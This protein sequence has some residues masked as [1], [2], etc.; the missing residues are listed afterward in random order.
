MKSTDKNLQNNTITGQHQQLTTG[1]ISQSQQAH[2][3]DSVVAVVPNDDTESE[4]VTGAVESTAERVGRSPG[5][6]VN[7]NSKHYHQRVREEAA[8]RINMED[9]GAVAGLNATMS[10]QVILY[11]LQV[12]FNKKSKDCGYTISNFKIHYLFK[13]MILLIIIENPLVKGNLRVFL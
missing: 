3:R 4:V 13:I 9:T 8:S 7:K 11:N 6:R 2:S 12:E 1:N 10:V 5:V